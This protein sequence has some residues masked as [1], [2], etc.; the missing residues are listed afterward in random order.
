MNEHTNNNEKF[1]VAAAYVARALPPL[2]E[3]AF[4]RQMMRDLELHDY[5]ERLQTVADDLLLAGPQVEPPPA[6]GRSILQAAADDLDARRSLAPEHPA[7]RRGGRFGGALLRPAFAAGFAV[8]LVAIAFVVGR[9]TAPEQAIPPA[10]DQ[11]AAVPLTPAAGSDSSGTIAMIGDGSSGALVKMEN[12]SAETDG[13]V[14]Q[15]WIQRGEQV[16]P[17]TLFDASSNGEAVAVIAEDMRD[18]DVVM[19]TEEPA[20]GSATP[21]GDVVAEVRF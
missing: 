6:L 20:G 13:R 15:L 7:P 16:T 12:L 4:R 17:S 5:V 9:D 21:S 1:D 14:Y 8:L 3:Q 2:E 19:I 10:I 18:A 11:Q